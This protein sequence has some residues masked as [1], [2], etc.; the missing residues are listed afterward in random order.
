MACLIGVLLIVLTFVYINRDM[1][2]SL[3]ILDKFTKIKVEQNNMSSDSNKSIGGSENSSN[4]DNVS[5]EFK[6]EAPKLHQDESN[7]AKEIQPS[8][9]F[10]AVQRDLEGNNYELLLNYLETYNKESLNLNEKALLIRVEEKIKASGVDHFYNLGMDAV[11]NN[12]YKQ[13]LVNFNKVFKYSEESY[14][15]P[16]MTYMLGFCYEKIY[17]VENANKYYELYLNKYSKGDYFEAALY[18]LAIIN[19]DIDKEKSKKICKCAGQ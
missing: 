14:L 13:G 1:I 15:N 9:N 19:K 17:D 11:K 2:K 10:E 5:E 8:F 7:A 18:S 4:R 6:E 12:D 16:H 3:N